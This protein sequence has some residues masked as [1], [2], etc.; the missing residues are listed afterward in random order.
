MLG[1]GEVLRGRVYRSVPLVPL[2]FRRPPLTAPLSPQTLK[3]S[4]PL[5]ATPPYSATWIIPSR[6]REDSDKFE[7]LKSAVA[8]QVA[9]IDSEL[10]V[11][12][13]ILK[14][15]ARPSYRRPIVWLCLPPPLA[16]LRASQSCL[17]LFTHPLGHYLASLIP[18]SRL[19][20]CRPGPVV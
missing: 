18:S 5:A 20:A 12:S 13:A 2:L 16:P 4:N 6:R 19:L 1:C 9:A 15:R 3:P 11:V 14:A 10:C 7:K 8:L 17:L